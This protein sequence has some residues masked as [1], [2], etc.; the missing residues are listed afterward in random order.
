M[1]MLYLCGGTGPV[2]PLMNPHKIITHSHK[3][4]RISI[5]QV[6]WAG[7][8]SESDSLSIYK[9]VKTANSKLNLCKLNNNWLCV[10]QAV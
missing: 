5:R 3:L 4:E 10:P 6:L 1:R 7:V 9:C 2:T 8:V